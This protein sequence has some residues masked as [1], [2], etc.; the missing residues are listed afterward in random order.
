[1]TNIFNP[2]KK[3]LI[4]RQF[5]GMLFFFVLATVLIIYFGKIM[6]P[7]LGA[8]VF[9][10]LLE[11]VVKFITSKKI[12]RGFAV[13]LVFSGFLL[14]FL[15][16]LF[17][18][19]PLIVLQVK[20][21]VKD[22]PTYIGLGQQL[23]MKLPEK[24]PDTITQE[25]ANQVISSLNSQVTN[26]AQSITSGVISKILGIITLAV[27]LVLVPVMIFFLLKDKTL[28]IKGL[29]K[30]LP[31]NNPLLK[32]V[33]ED[34]DVQIGNYIRGKF[35]EILILWFVSF[36]AFTLFGLDYAM[37]LSVVVGLSVLVP[38]IGATVV[39]LPVVLV[40]YTQWGLTGTFYGLSITYFIIQ[41][42]DGNVLVPLIFSE[43]VNINPVGILVAVLFFG[44]IWGFWG[45]FFAIPIATVVKSILDAWVENMGVKKEINT[46]VEED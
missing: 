7:F 46:K 3:I 13:G 2:F 19:F 11:G 14:F 4:N 30:Y 18:A 23:I 21:F 41:I 32:S 39:T 1:M 45:V 20:E 8:V 15:S 36:V 43:A 37:L 16:V 33:W 27:Y 9:A 22:I 12:S 35:T 34:V 44:G 10:Y 38:Y 6:A 28:I 31:L 25:Q 24:Y 42:L 40:A 29:Q 5:A 17:F 26:F